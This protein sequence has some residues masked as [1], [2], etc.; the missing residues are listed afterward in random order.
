MST[1]RYRTNYRYS[2]S[3]AGKWLALL[4]LL[5]A[6]SNSSAATIHVPTQ[7]GTIQSG[8]DLSVNGDTVLIAPGTYHERINFD[9]KAIIVASRYLTTGDPGYNEVTIIDADPAILGPTDTGSVV[10]F[11]NG[12]GAGSV[13][14]GLTIQN[15]T[16]TARTGPGGT[17]YNGGGIFCSS[18][19]P[20]IRDCVI[21]QNIVTGN[22]G[23][24]YCK[25]GSGPAIINCRFEVNQCGLLGGAFTAEFSSPILTNCIFEQNAAVPPFGVS[26]GCDFFYSTPVL[27]NCEFIE[28]SSAFASGGVSCYSSPAVFDR[29]VFNGN[30]SWFAGGLYCYFAPPTL[31]NCTFVFNKA[32]NGA[33]IYSEACAFN[34]S[35]SILAYNQQGAAILAMFDSIP[36]I[37]CTDI[38][39]NSGGDWFGNI[40]AQ[41]NING[42]MATDPLFCDALG[43]DFSIDSLSPCGP[44]YNSCTTLIGAYDPN[45]SGTLRVSVDPDTMHTIDLNSVNPTDVLVLLGN[46]SSGYS[47]DDIDLPSLRVNDSL[48]PDSLAVLTGYPDFAGQVVAMYFSTNRYLAQ[49]GWMWDVTMHPCVVT[50]LFNSKSDIELTTMVTLM[51]HI[52]G[53]VNNDGSRDISDLVL[54]VDYFFNSGDALELSDAVDLDRNGQIDIT[55]LI[56][57]VEL[58]FGGNQPE[59]VWERM[60][61]YRD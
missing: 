25:D 1:A 37:M 8:I 56:A 58:M 48:V 12:E 21:R 11:V 24:M 49:Y 22:G 54:V 39:G 6:A 32:I 60:L 19:S 29:C 44:D 35:N 47:V 59:P 51:G 26:G 45:C 43:I 9:G 34:L 18:A 10:M 16:G 52:S 7:A 46:F 5:T 13:L 50:G 40:A 2:P 31:T 61:R 27:T 53:D 30:Q 17:F 41:A 15:G 3:H 28:N 20:T 36:N 38:Y 33:G 4:L 55:D 57:L 42:N 23:G 14:Y